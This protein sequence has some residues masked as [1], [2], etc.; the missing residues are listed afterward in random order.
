MSAR[1]RHVKDL[2]SP[3]PITNLRLKNPIVVPLT[4]TLHTWPYGAKIWRDSPSLPSLYSSPLPSTNPL[5]PP[6]SSH[7]VDVDTQGLRG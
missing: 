5:S 2:A 6:L 3:D 1:T 7:W 4:S